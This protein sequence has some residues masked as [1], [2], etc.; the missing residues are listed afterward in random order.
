MSQWTCRATKASIRTIRLGKGQ[1]RYPQS[2]NQPRAVDSGLLL[3]GE[4][5]GAVLTGSPLITSA[6][7]VTRPFGELAAASNHNFGAIWA[8][9]TSVMRAPIPLVPPVI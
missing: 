4:A 3:L 5:E 2:T 7:P 9:K 8:T 6:L 1:N